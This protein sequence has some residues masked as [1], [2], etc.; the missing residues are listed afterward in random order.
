MSNFKTIGYISLVVVFLME[1]GAIFVN[2]SEGFSAFY[3]FDFSQRFSTDNDLF[4]LYWGAAIGCIFLIRDFDSSSV[5]SLDKAFNLK[6]KDLNVSTDF[7]E[8]SDKK[9]ITSPKF[10]ERE[11]GYDMPSENNLEFKEFLSKYNISYLECKHKWN[12]YWKIIYTKWQR[13]K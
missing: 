6:K 5:P 7:S 11:L 13:D 3:L 10:K 9:P 2:I 1:L 4:L 8:H 12:G